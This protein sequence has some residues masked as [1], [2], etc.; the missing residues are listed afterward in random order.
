MYWLTDSGNLTHKVIIRPA[1]SLAQ[2]R[3]VRQPR[4]AFYRLCYAA[5]N[6]IPWSRG[7]RL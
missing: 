5:N 7:I 3:E 1:Y 6:A 4:P 2:D